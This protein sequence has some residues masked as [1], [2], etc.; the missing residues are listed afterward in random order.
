[1][2][3]NGRLLSIAEKL[4]ACDILVDIGTD[5]GYIPIYAVKNNICKKAIASDLREGPL[6]AALRN[7]KK[8][9]VER[10][11]ELRQGNGLESILPYECDLIVIAGM[12]GSLIRDILSE[13][14]EK[15]KRAK[16]LVLQPNTALFHLR[17]WLYENGFDIVDE[18][19]SFDAGKFYCIISTKWTGVSNQME[20]EDYYLGLKLFS[21]KDPLLNAYLNKK[22][23]ELNVIITGR[24]R[25][26]KENKHKRDYDNDIST[27][28][29][30]KIKERIVDYLEGR[31]E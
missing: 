23:S 21:S 28:S 9:S 7:I 29:C 15:A 20:D 27:V 25:S 14:L 5:H 4:P 24:A 1:M 31:R 17:K 2:K 11:I 30:I 13:S 16:L 18:A 12:G 10:K 8:N 6:K 3:L 26:N 19:L 22:L